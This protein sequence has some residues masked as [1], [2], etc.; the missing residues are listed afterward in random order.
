MKRSGNWVL[1]EHH[2][3]TTGEGKVR[4]NMKIEWNFEK[5]PIKILSCTKTSEES[6]M[7]KKMIVLNVYQILISHKKNR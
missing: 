2:T 5:L 7:V 4:K 3:S 1:G 6:N